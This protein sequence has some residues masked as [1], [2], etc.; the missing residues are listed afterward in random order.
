[1]SE[2]TAAELR[3]LKEDYAK[4]TRRADIAE[5]LA[6]NPDFRELVLNCFMVEDAA[7]YVRQSADPAMTAEQ[8]ADCIALAQSAG[9][10]KRW[11]SLQTQ[12][13]TVARRNMDEL[14]QAI[15]EAEAE[16]TE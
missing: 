8:R 14:D 13:A 3:L 15:I 7:H 16:E 2:V 5:R 11:L 6:A 1:M 12:I 4:A 9:H 10:F